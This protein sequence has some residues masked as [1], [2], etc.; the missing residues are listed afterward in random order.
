MK[1]TFSV[2]VTTLMLLALSRLSALAGFTGVIDMNLTM[3]N[4]TSEILYFFGRNA[5]RMDMTTKLDKIPDSLYTTVITRKSEPDLAV[6][7]NHKAG[8][9]KKISLKTA[10]ETTTLVDFDSDYRIV[11]GQSAT[12]QGYQCDHV[13][14]SSSTDTIEMWLT[15][16]IG[17]F[18]TFRLLQSQNP[19]LSN[20]VLSEKLAEEGIDGFPVRVIQKNENGQLAMEVVSVSRKSVETDRFSVPEGYSELVDEQ[21]PLNNRQ[22]EHLKD[23]MDKI[24]DF[25]E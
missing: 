7:V 15:E 24:K 19:R 1:K 4:G 16:D 10:L 18:E 21:K 23:L 11:R 3:P 9:Y 17:D 13:T 12:I 22:K 14:L 25:K 2:I 20:T 6:I 8:T 5:Q